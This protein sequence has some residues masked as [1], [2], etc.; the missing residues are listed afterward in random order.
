MKYLKIKRCDGIYDYFPLEITSFGFIETDD[1]EYR[2]EI[3]CGNRASETI[4]EKKFIYQM[5]DRMKTI[6]NLPDGCV[7]DIQEL[8]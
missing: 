1:N 2:V 7:V 6:A 3:R 8:F 5:D 4:F